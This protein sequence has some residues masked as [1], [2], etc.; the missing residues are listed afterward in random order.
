MKQTVNFNAFVDAFQ[1]YDRYDQFGYEALRAL[2]DNIE[3]MEQDTGEE[4]E[5]DVI[6]LCCDWACYI[7]AIE[8]CND[9]DTGIE[10]TREVYT[11]G[12][13]MSGYMPDSEPQQFDDLGEA[14]DYIADSIE[15]YADSLAQS[16]DD[17]ADSVAVLYATAQFVRDD[18]GELGLTVGG[19]HYW[20]TAETV[21]VDDAE[22][23]CL[24]WLQEQ[25][26]VIGFNGGILVGAF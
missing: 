16:T 7:S 8:A 25:T 10:T 19:W 5:L 9:Y 15:S 26:Q 18:S 23:Q 17:T 6:A 22:E 13:N 12:W 21:S 11:A 3:E 14:R 20:I 2:F 24:E 4:M 1:A